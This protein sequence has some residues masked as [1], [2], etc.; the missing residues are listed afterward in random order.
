MVYSEIL[1]EPG[2]SHR[3]AVH[4]AGWKSLFSYPYP[5][6][7]KMTAVDLGQDPGEQKPRDISDER[8]VSWVPYLDKE[9]RRADGLL[10]ARTVS[11]L[12][13]VPPSADTLTLP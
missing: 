12:P 11:R 8:G 10:A 6:D 1:A 7:G 5:A 4:G 13:T 9:C 3:V 2:A